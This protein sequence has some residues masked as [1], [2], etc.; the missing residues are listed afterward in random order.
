M[1]SYQ[2]NHDPIEVAK[3][4]KRNKYVYGVSSLRRRLDR[5]FLAGGRDQLLT[6]ALTRGEC[7]ACRCIRVKGEEWCSLHLAQ[8]SEKRREY[9]SNILTATCV[10]CKKRRALQEVKYRQ[11]VV[12]SP[13]EGHVT[14]SAREEYTVDY[15]Y[16]SDEACEQEYDSLILLHLFE[17]W[18]RWAKTLGLSF[19]EYVYEDPEPKT[20]RPSFWRKIQLWKQYGLPGSRLFPRTDKVDKRYLSHRNEQGRTCVIRCCQGRPVGDAKACVRHERR[21]IARKRGETRCMLRTCHRP[22][23]T[24]LLPESHWEAAGKADEQDGPVMAQLSPFCN[25]HQRLLKPS[26]PWPGDAGPTVAEL[27]KE[28]R[29]KA[30][31]AA[32]DPRHKRIK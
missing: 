8:W 21:I 17:I 27:T 11:Q 13:T 14:L 24:I 9:E 4:R 7:L 2:Y 12:R 19:E 3:V 16:C 6:Y 5:W 28:A 29:A 1:P 23:A 20:Y 22:G 30:W 25:E 10:T 32:R 18:Q 31:L 15:V 26:E